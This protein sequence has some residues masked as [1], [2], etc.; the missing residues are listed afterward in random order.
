MVETRLHPVILSGGSGSR[1]WP[2]SRADHPKQ[3]LPLTETRTLLQA[4]AQRFA[5]RA[6]FQAPL[7]IANDA[8]RFVVGEQ[9]QNAGVRDARI[10]LEPVGRN[11]APAAAVAALLIGATDPDALIMLL[12]SDHVIVDHDRFHAAVARAAETARTGHLVTFGITPTA[13]STEYGYIRRGAALAG[14]A[15]QVERFVEKPDAATAA[16]YLADGTYAWNSGMF[17]FPVA[18]FLKELAAH[19]PDILAACEK[20]VAG[21]RVDLDFQRLDEA[22]FTACPAD[23]ID[24]AVMERTAVAAVVAGDFGWNDVGAWRA[25]WDLADRGDADNA[26][27]G[28]VIAE[29]CRGS[30]LRAE[31]G[32]LVAAIGVENLCVIAT[33][34]AVFVAPLERTAEV[35]RLVENLQ[36]DGRREFANHPRVLRPWG[37][38]TDIERDGRFK[39]KRLVVRPGRRLSLQKHAHRSEHWVVVQG[40]ATVV[41]GDREFTLER[42]QSTYITAG[43]VHRLENRGAEDLHLIEVQVGDYL[44]EDDI[45]RLEDDFKRG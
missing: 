31:P 19:R 12:P 11:T 45:V 25:L 5:D 13:P 10:V 40:T 44:E 3:L 22:A 39:V 41:N 24:Y 8:H 32:M 6:R 43:D 42:D 37:S 1:L 35:K 20:A 38:Y 16:S 30:Y 9:L 34:D 21:Q 36:R 2:L 7:V 18:L 23:S 4:T 28:D 26:L 14:G 33:G 17:V 27:V 15:H 29:D